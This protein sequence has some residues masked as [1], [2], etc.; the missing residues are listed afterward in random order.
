MLVSVKPPPPLQRPCSPLGEVSK[1]PPAK[2]QRQSQPR[3]QVKATAPVTGQKGKPKPK[4]KTTI[5]TKAK[6][7]TRRRPRPKKPLPNSTGLPSLPA[8]I[9]GRIASY[10]LPPAISVEDG[11]LPPGEL[12]YNDKRKKWVGAKI[13]RHG[14]GGVPSGVRD[15]LNLA[16]TC[17]QCDKGVSLVI[18]KTGDGQSDG[19]KR[20][21]FFLIG[22]D[23]IGRCILRFLKKETGWSLFDNDILMSRMS[24]KCLIESLLRVMS[25]KSWSFIR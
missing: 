23:E 7:K 16:L 2:R 20:Y 22:A 5:T 25:W 12:P 4:T 17:R 3:T 14:Y 19:K 13:K 1:P 21:A 24:R 9:I 8:E 11:F 6:P 15:V 10:L 18:G